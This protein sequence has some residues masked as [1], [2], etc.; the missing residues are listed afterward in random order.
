VIGSCK[1]PS[2]FPRY[3]NGAYS[4]AFRI[5]VNL[6]PECGVRATYRWQTVAGHSQRRG[7]VGMHQP[8]AVQGKWL[9]HVVRGYFNYHAVPTNS[10]AL[11]AFRTEIVKS[12]HR[13][14]TRTQR[15]GDSQLGPHEPAD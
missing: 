15:A 9:W 11:V 10:R 8:I 13:V 7:M 6:S 14:L 5:D 3:G 4:Y 12:W 2:A 1:P